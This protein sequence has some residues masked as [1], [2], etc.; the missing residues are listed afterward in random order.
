MNILP[1][2]KTH[3]SLGKSILM[4]Y[5]EKEAEKDKDGKT[6]IT[7]WP[8]SESGP[9]SIVGIIKKHKLENITI[10]DDTFL[11]FPQIYKELGK[12]TNVVFGINLI[13]AQDAKDKSEKSQKTE[14]KISI[15]MKNSDGYKDLL[16][17]HNL[18][19]TSEDY[20]YYHY[21]CDWNILKELWTDNLALIIPPYD[22]F[23]HL[24]SFTDY[25]C[26]PD[27][28]KI[29]PIMT[30]ARMELPIDDLLSEVIKKYA[31]NNKFDL[32]EVHPVYYYKD[33]DIKAYMNYRCINGRAQFS[34]PEINGFCSPYFSFEAYCR[35]VGINFQ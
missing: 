30:I 8:I 35:K 7:E 15:L 20:F 3:G 10:I 2:F 5:G 12:I 21:R 1:I 33:S 19:H 6:L 23:I 28:G 14:S 4:T 18:I 31:L 29:K 16:R 9:I 24:N 32:Q 26:I 34:K 11:S 27:F 25:N 22:N 17:I 13:V